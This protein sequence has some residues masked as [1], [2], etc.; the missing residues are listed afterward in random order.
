VF[1]ER[2]EGV[3]VRGGQVLVEKDD[4]TVHMDATV[5]AELMRNALK[6]YKK[7][8]GNLPARIVCHKTSYFD[9]GETQGFGD[10]VDQFGIDQLDLVSIRK[11]SVRFFRGKPNPP[12]RGTAIEL[13]DRTSVLY[14]Q[15]S[16]DFYRAYPGL[17]VPRPIEVQFDQIERQPESI[18]A[19][20]LA[21]SKMNWN[22][23]RF[24]NSDPIT[25]AAAKNVGNVL[26]YLDADSTVP[27][28]YSNYM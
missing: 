11:S 22:S 3:V 10:V 6:L 26:R 2:G 5:S 20:I 23:T 28:R 18:L 9:E 21:L 8:H 16:V 1:N 14:T 15:G 12:L 17:Y 19:E 25:V 7:E 27:V 13:D 4:R 24:V